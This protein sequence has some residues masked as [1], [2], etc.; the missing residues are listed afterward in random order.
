MAV[1]IFLLLLL[2]KQLSDNCQKPVMG[3]LDS[4][5]FCLNIR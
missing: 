3:I 2:G 5:S 4:V 1:K